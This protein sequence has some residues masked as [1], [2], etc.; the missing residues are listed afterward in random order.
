VAAKTRAVGGLE[1]HLN[2]ENV[3]EKKGRTVVYTRSGGIKEVQGG[4]S[5]LVVVLVVGWKGAK[6]QGCVRVRAGARRTKWRW[7]T[8]TLIVS[9]RAVDS[10]AFVVV[11]DATKSVGCKKLELGRPQCR[12]RDRVGKLLLGKPPIHLFR[13][14]P[15]LS[16]EILKRWAVGKTV[17]DG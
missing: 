3:V 7:V 13:P 5:V 12:S 9:R 16:V 1:G 4:E 11:W 8:G 17:C 10:V 14:D 2:S 15:K 6:C